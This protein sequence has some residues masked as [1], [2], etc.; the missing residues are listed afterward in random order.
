MYWALA[1]LPLSTRSWSWLP[2]R[3][4]EPRSSKCTAAGCRSKKRRV[5]HCS[6]RPTRMCRWT[7]GWRRGERKRER[8]LPNWRK[9]EQIFQLTALLYLLLL[10]TLPHAFLDSFLPFYYK[11]PQRRAAF[12][13]R[14]GDSRGVMSRDFFCDLQYLCQLHLTGS[15]S[16]RKDKLNTVCSRMGSVWSWP[17][18]YER[19]TD[20]LRCKH[21]GYGLVLKK[22]HLHF[23]W[24]FPLPQHQFTKNNI[25][26]KPESILLA[27]DQI[28]LSSKLTQLI[29]HQTGTD[30][31]QRTQN[32]IIVRQSWSHIRW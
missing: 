17:L 29:S 23:G 28:I 11:S 18:S 26:S 13:S 24:N 32:H 7:M 30:F 3:P 15:G 20:V 4:S 27:V 1:S 21:T 31:L 12:L 16:V 10:P 22:K 19:G 25:L 8:A 2:S 5:S 6:C 14:L 9:D